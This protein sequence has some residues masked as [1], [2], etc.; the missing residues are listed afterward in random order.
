MCSLGKV[1]IL[2][3]EERDIS[4]LQGADGLACSF[5]RWCSDKDLAPHRTGAP[6]LH[7]SMHLSFG[8]IIA[9]ATS[10]YAVRTD[11]GTQIHLKYSALASIDILEYEVSF[12]NGQYQDNQL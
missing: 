4:Q 2:L 11:Q 3:Y 9:A 8:I 6:K 1:P 7:L 12:A 10:I 5:G